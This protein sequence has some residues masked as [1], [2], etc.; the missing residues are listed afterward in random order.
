MTADANDAAATESVTNPDA[1]EQGEEEMKE[2]KAKTG[3]EETE[4]GNETRQPA[5]TKS[6]ADDLICPIS[7]ELPWDPVIAMD[8]R[9]YERK[10]IEAYIQSHPHDLKSPITRQTMGRTLLP[11]IQHRNIIETA[12]E[13]G[14]MPDDLSKEWNENVQQ[15]K[16]M[17]ETLKEAEAG[18]EDSMYAAAVKYENGTKGF[19]QDLKLAFHWVEK[20][21]L[22]GHVMATAVMGSYYLNGCGVEECLHLGI[23]YASVAAAQGSDWAA[24]ILGLTFAQ[25]IHGVVMDKSVAVVWLKKA[26]GECAHKY[27]NDQK[28]QSL[29]LLNELKANDSSST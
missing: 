13:K 23:M 21:H 25:G 28:K 12:I 1:A 24:Y 26:L 2:E 27:M 17:E 29:E 16:L 22:A 15:K 11:A 18:D 3:G 10:C 8:G 5:K 14:E 6:F 7:H 4:Q 19:K 9:V 20:A